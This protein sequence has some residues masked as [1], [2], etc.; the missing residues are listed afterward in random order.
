MVHGLPMRN[1]GLLS[2]TRGAPLRCAIGVA[3]G[4]GAVG[5]NAAPVNPPSVFGQATTAPNG[6]KN[7]ERGWQGAACLYNLLGGTA[8]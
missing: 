3:P 1:T 7:E 2:G 5:M 6:R 8:C 4:A